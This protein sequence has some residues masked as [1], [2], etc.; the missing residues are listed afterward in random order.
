MAW[1]EHIHI[2][3]HSDTETQKKLDLVLAK[4]D[5]LLTDETDQAAIAKAATDLD[6]STNELDAAVKKNTPA[7]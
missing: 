3:I 4:L 6:K 1:S 7:P 5:Q 2:H